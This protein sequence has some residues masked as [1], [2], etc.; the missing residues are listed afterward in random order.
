MHPPYLSV[1]RIKLI[2][3][4]CSQQCQA[5]MSATQTLGVTCQ[6]ARPEKDGVNKR[7]LRLSDPSA[8]PSEM[9]ELPKVEQPCRPHTRHRFPAP[10]L[11]LCS[12]SPQSVPSASAS[13]CAQAPFSDLSP[14]MNRLSAL[15]HCQR[16]APTS[17][18]TPIR[19]S[20]PPPPLA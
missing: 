4:K 20:A 9:G 19:V 13:R 3:T 15:V 18:A 10:G 2:N 14:M 11:P 17:A 16:L 5:H 12:S 7:I 8:C 1:A 6:E